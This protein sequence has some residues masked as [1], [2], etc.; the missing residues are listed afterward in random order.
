LRTTGLVHQGRG[1][2]YE[3]M[4]LY[5][6]ALEAYAVAEERYRALG[7]TQRLGEILDNRGA[8]LLYLGRGNEA[9]EAHEAAAAVFGEAGLTLSY[10]K[11]LCNIGE[12]NRRLANYRSSLTAFEEAR[13]IYDT[14]DARADKSLLMLDTANAYLDLNLYS[15]ALAAY[16]KANSLLRNAGMVHD[17]ARALWGMGVA[18]TAKSDLE[19][20]EAEGS[21]RRPATRRCSR[22]LC[23]TNQLYKRPAGTVMPPWRPRGGRSASFSRK[24]GR[25]N[26]YT[27]TYAWPT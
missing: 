24:I 7:E 11:A 27:R 23:L 6:E 26:A 17:R 18:L 2:C 3:Y 5:E 14:L 13:R 10:A 4:G 19:G 21:S 20:A 16:Q 8:I 12:A 25:C 1:G 15:E 22:A 9:L